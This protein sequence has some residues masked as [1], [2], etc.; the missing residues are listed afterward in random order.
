MIIF[1]DIIKL[2]IFCTS[3]VGI[4]TLYK[5]RKLK[6]GI[7]GE[8]FSY[9]VS[10]FLIGSGIILILPDGPLFKIYN[11]IFISTGFFYFLFRVI[12][13]QLSFNLTFSVYFAIVVIFFS[14]LL[15]EDSYQI[16]DDYLAYF[17]LARKLYEANS[18]FDP[19]FFRRVG[20]LGGHTALHSSLLL[21]F[22]EIKFNFLE[23]GVFRFCFA[24]S[25]L[26][27][28]SRV[29]SVN[30]VVVFFIFLIFLFF[31]SP[32]L[33]TASYWT[34]ATILLTL[35]VRLIEGEKTNA[36]K[37]DICILTSALLTLRPT[38]VFILPITYFVFLLKEKKLFIN[39]KYL[40]VILVLI[41]PW[42]ISSYQSSETPFF[43]FFKGNFNESY[44]TFTKIGASYNYLDIV[45]N[46]IYDD[47]IFYC[48]VFLLLSLVL[49]KINYIHILIFL[50]PLFSVL[51]NLKLPE[52][53]NPIHGIR[54]TFPFVVCGLFL[55]I[56]Q[57]C[58]Y[59]NYRK[60]FKKYYAVTSIVVVL[61]IFT[62]FSF[63]KMYLYSKQISNFKFLA[64]LYSYS[65]FTQV[66]KDIQ[67]LQ[68]LTSPHDIIIT[69][70]DQPFLFD[71]T[72]NVIYLFDVPGQYAPPPGLPLGAKC[73]DLDSYLK[74][75]NVK[76]ILFID[77]KES[78]IEYSEKFW[79][80]M[81]QVDVLQKTGIDKYHV[82]LSKNLAGEPPKKI[83]SYF[84]NWIKPHLQFIDYLKCKKELGFV[85]KEGNY[86]LSK[87]Q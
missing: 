66:Q 36:S 46:T 26:E 74:Q 34:G 32:V 37:I 76:Y 42:M 87:I 47:Y 77:P 17:P 4:G 81:Y 45:L 39:W 73:N 29:K 61:L 48:L 65:G 5:K 28:I 6:I 44:G 14:G 84:A 1:F 58:D 85:K 70:I 68:S 10:L 38:Y 12:K 19:F 41:S 9:G 8:S 82:L 72:R 80:K 22:S 35:V 23:L 33:N 57:L 83:P 63:S 53:E 60:V 13:D 54:Y 20:S 49:N 43:P 55:V 30:K 69:A 31:D 51:I 24:L 71:F 15:F 7:I 62:I 3:F 40:L 16:W 50:F 78:R 11:L 25:A 75:H 2:F 64:K 86:Y 67:A 59:D 79:I 56:M 27:V 18:L 52:A 21:F